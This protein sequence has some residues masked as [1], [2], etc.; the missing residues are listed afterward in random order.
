M[1][2]INFPLKFPLIALLLSCLNL[3]GAIAVDSDAHDLGKIQWED[4]TPINWNPTQIF[5]D[6]TD[7]E[8]NA[9]SDNELLRLEEDVQ[10]LLDTAPVNETLNGKRVKIPGFI[11]PLEFNNTLL[12][13][14]LL[15]PYFG[16]CTHTPPPPANQIIFGKLT[17]DSEL[18]DV[19][20]PVWI[21]GT[22]K[23]SR[24]NSLLNE[25]GITDGLE[26]HSAYSMAVES[27]EPYVD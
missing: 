21:T 23:T 16:A 20:Q 11:L 18:K 12:S 10:A 13:E 27:I 1:T 2:D 3:N 7:Q 4:L 14:F 17:V 24:S 8:Y 25:E 19:F 26:V 22:L 6:M 5:N 15:V 9:L